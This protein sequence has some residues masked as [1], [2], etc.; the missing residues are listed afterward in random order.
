MTEN[1][2]WNAAYLQSEFGFIAE[3]LGSVRYDLSEESHGFVRVKR[4]N[5]ESPTGSPATS[6]IVSIVKEV[7]NMGHK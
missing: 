1:I 3:Q 2:G 6:T 4:Q 7:G 5:V